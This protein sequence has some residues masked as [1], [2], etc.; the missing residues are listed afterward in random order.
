MYMPRFLAPNQKITNYSTWQLLK[1]TYHYIRPHRRLFFVGSLL[2]LIGEVLNLY[3][4]Y[5]LGQMVNL[6]SSGNIAENTARLWQ[7]VILVTITVTLSIITR[8][9]ARRIINNIGNRIAANVEL[10]AIS[11]I[12]KL[13]IAWHEKENTGNKLKRIQNA[14]SGFNRL[15]NIWGN[16]VISIAVNFVGVVVIVYQFDKTIAFLTALFLTIYFLINKILLKR[17]AS[18]SY[19]VNVASED[20]SGLQFEAVNNIRSVKIMSMINT[21]ID[22]LKFYSHKWYDFTQIKVFWMANRATG[23]HVIGFISKTSM[24]IYILKKIIDGQ[25]DVGFLVFFN[26]YFNRIWESVDQLSNVSEDIL[27][28]RYS[29]SRLKS[30][31]AEPIKID[32]ETD[33]H[34]FPKDWNQIKLKNVSFA[35]GQNQV[36]KNINLTINKGERIGIIGLSGAGKSTLFKL[37]LKE[38]ENFDGE[39][40]INDVPI[41]EVGKHEYFKHIAVVLQDTEVFNFSLRENI[42]LAGPGTPN[43]EK[44]LQKALEIA[45]VTD[46]LPKLPDGVDT[47]IGEK[48]VRLSGGEKQRLG[49]ARAVFKNPQLLLLDEATSHLDLESEEKIQDSLHKFFQS[50]TA[51]V[52]AHRLTTIKEMDKIVVIENGEI[53]ESGNFA[54]LTAKQGRFYELWEKQRL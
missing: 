29:I 51:V 38:Y 49:I 41:Q 13:D 35:Y 12:F 39:I 45:H 5:A 46:F 36:L 43:K 4:P 44:E 54:K 47:P 15:I 23:G 2:L 48:G 42:Y 20:I 30:M 25:L 11:H 28:A 33:K 10:E 37:L 1:D 16:N 14:S 32:D 9:F 24:L 18:S 3:S 31:M 27:V 6:L 26:A 19:N 52:I 34:Q 53:I 40:L 17:V 21:L 50:V 22:K 8:Y 7:V